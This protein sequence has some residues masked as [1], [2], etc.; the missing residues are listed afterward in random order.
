MPAFYYWVSG[1]ALWVAFSF[2]INVVFA[3]IG[4]SQIV[5]SKFLL[6]IVTVAFALMVIGWWNAAEQQKDNEQNQ[7]ILNEIRAA[8]PPVSVNGSIINLSNISNNQIRVLV[9]E[10]SRNLR[11]F[12]AEWADSDSKLM[13]EIFYN[14]EL[15]ESERNAQWLFNS[16][17]RSNASVERE[18]K[19]RNEIR[20]QVLALIEEMKKRIKFV[21]DEKR[22]PVALE[23]GM[24][25]GRAPMSDLADYLE[26]FARQLEP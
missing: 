9:A 1:S 21:A 4:I 12:E 11:K 17:V 19:F 18:A 10:S 15:N 26:L 24:L 5:S 25:A 20:P 3:A 14:R 16:K 6:F 8:L 13:N 23:F 2:L 22:A 7:R